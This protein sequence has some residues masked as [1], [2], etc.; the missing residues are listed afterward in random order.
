MNSGTVLARHR[1][2]DHHHHGRQRDA[3]NRRDVANEV[4]AEILIVR[5]AD[6]RGGA[7]QEQRVA[8]GRRGDD[9]FDPDRAAGA[10]A[11]LDD[12]LLAKP[13]RQPFANEPGKNV[14]R[15]AGSKADD[16]MYRP[17]PISLRGSDA[18]CGR[19][20]GGGRRQMEEFSARKCHRSLLGGFPRLDDRLATGEP[21]V[22]CAQIIRA[23]ALPRL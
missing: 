15:A 10:G 23:S 1:W 6:G 3:A 12:E 14:G 5:R 20:D 9:G 18:D 2:I 21:R 16:H 7:D 19:T 8:V 17:C 13:L 11:V 4:E 22:I